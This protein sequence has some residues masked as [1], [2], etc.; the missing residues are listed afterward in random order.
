MLLF[1]PEHTPVSE[2]VRLAMA[3]P[4]LHHRTSEFKTMLS[5]EEK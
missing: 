5:K 2:L 4:A 3:T 1:T